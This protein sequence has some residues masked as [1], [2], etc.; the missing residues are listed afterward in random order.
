MEIQ[1]IILKIS[2]LETRINDL[3]QGSIGIKNIKGNTYYYL[4]Y[5]ENGKRVEQYID[6]SIL[7]E[8]TEKIELRKKLELE[9]KELRK[10]ISHKINK[11]NSNL[12][13]FISNILIGKELKDFVIGVSKY[14]KRKC[15]E[16]IQNYI[17]NDLYDK[18][19]IL[20]GLRRT[21]KTTLIRQTILE[22][23]DVDFNKTA[24]IQ[25]KSSD[26][27]GDLNKDLRKLKIMGY[28]YV[29]IDEVTLLEDFIEGAALFSDIYASSG[30][31]IVLSG[32]D[33]LGF[34]FA[35]ND[36]LYDRSIL[37]HTTFIPYYEFEYVL[38]IKGINEYIRYGG[39]MS[40]SGIKYNH[41]F[42]F[43][44]KE[45]VDEY[46][47]TSIARNIQHSLKYY[48][49][50]NHFRHLQELYENNE[51]TNI[52]NRVVEDIN[53]RFT[54]EVL[55]KEFKSSDLS[56]SSRNLR[57]DK[58][59][60][61]T[62]LDEIDKSK[63]NDRLKEMLEIIDINEQTITLDET[64]A[65]EIKEYLTLLDLIYEINERSFPSVNDI[66]KNVVIAQPGLRYAQAQSLVE[67]LLLD[68]K[69]D[70]LSLEEREYVFLRILNEIKGRMME[71]IVLLET[72]IAK[73]GKDVFKLKFAI[74]EFD[75]VVF[76]PTTLSCE[77]YEVKYSEDIVSEQ[78]KHLIDEEKIRLTENKFGIITNKN[79]IYRGQTTKIDNIQYINIEEYLN[80]LYNMKIS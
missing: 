4:R 42:V 33:S 50:G 26:T 35:K 48:R 20:Y 37:L 8:I 63:F 79:V 2:E 57:S 31:K 11:K 15:F 25:V 80:S 47:D 58:I 30:M 66:K 3:P 40:L 51:L 34:V 21:G 70:D 6:F 16:Q 44:N 22:M 76:D 18:V 12:Y 55:T 54:K 59:S 69:F 49:D 74:G 1:D 64:H 43:N 14:K 75:M 27:L 56:L 78:Y 24:F 77:I 60:P 10:K 72:K 52:I 19:L 73:N 17:Y 29:F 61:I 28:S 65:L 46:I 71:D 62:I 68:K 36:Q 9:L 67:S 39:T 53:H 41:D 32:T 7:P 23:N 45:N 38:G 5:N 13:G